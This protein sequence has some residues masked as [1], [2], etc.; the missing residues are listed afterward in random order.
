[1]PFEITP[2][3]APAPQPAPGEFIQWR[4]GG[5]NRGDNRVVVIDF[6]GDNI[7]ATRG[8]GA[9]SN[10]VT[11]RR[12]SSAPPPPPAPVA[13]FYALR[14]SGTASYFSQNLFVGNGFDSIPLP[15]EGYP[16]LFEAE[17]LFRALSGA[18]APYT[19][20]SE[21]A[22]S[23]G[24]LLEFFADASSGVVVTVSAAT[25]R[26][27][28][29]TAGSTDGGG[30]YSVAHSDGAGGPTP[31][32]GGTKFLSVVTNNATVTFAFPRLMC[33]FGLYLIDM[34]DF[35][36]TCTIKFFNGAAEIYSQSFVPSDGAFDLAEAL[37]DG[38]VGFISYIAQTTA[39]PFDRVTLTF[40]ATAS[41]RTGFDNFLVATL[42]GLP[43][44]YITAGQ[45]V[46]FTDT[47]TNTPTEWAWTFGDST[48][49]ALQ[50]PTKTYS[51]PGTYTVSLTAGNAGGSDTET[52]TGLI[53]VT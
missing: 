41:D 32:D 19:F 1:M 16:A 21:S 22:T 25:G 10:V 35:G 5:V 14:S 44:L 26:I 29:V 49:S 4:A 6:V 15:P 50:N 52:K 24:T 17:D 9:N 43:A 23:D 8:V 42:E 53:E 3:P 48:T 45:T 13:D 37:R 46:Q 47:S 36:G 27:A 28:S 40:S 12:L 18:G 20:E 11:V 31:A 33:G 2:A 34:M 51:T 39:A 7:L 30:R 38:S